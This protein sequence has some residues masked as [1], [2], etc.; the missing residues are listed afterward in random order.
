MKIIGL[1]FAF[2]LLSLCV[3]PV[4]VAAQVDAQSFD[5]YGLGDYQGGHLD[6]AAAEFQQAVRLLPHDGLAFGYL[7]RIFARKGQTRQA[8]DAYRKA[9]RYKENAQ[10]AY[11]NP[12]TF[13]DDQGPY[14][15]Q[16]IA[17]FK[18]ALARDPNDAHARNSLG[19]AYYDQGA[20]G[21]DGDKLAL[22]EFR[23]AIR[24]DP[25]YPDPHVNLGTL[26]AMLAKPKA[27]VDEYR[28][29]LRLDP[30][31]AKAHNN[32]GWVLAEQNEFDE[33]G[34][35]FEAALRLQ[36]GYV[37]AA[38]N[39]A[40]IHANRA[41]ALNNAGKFAQALPEF[42]QAIRLAPTDTY[43][44]LNLGLAFDEQGRFDESI[45]A[46]REAV[47]LTPNDAESHD[48]LAHALDDAGRLEAAVVEY[49]RA[50]QIEPKATDLRL[51]LALALYAAGQKTEARQEWQQLTK[52]G[53]PDTIDEARRHLREFP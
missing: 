51:M 24:I 17:N 7:G 47:R 36:P 2:A 40:A 27:A 21:G 32:L 37:H 8:L 16:A 41:Q 29:A 26:M 12:A 13:P 14:D 28:E 44:R 46:Y 4:R 18:Q 49:R 11:T 42:Q 10:D 5:E 22:I 3:C 31:N 30:N 52:R 33:A 23:R 50:A 35:E 45:A 38:R 1:A 15:A 48:R 39:L 34:A 19:V 6:K 9:L 20:L 43:L 25:K 53:N